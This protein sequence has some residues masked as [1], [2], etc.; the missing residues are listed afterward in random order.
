MSEPKK[1]KIFHADC[2]DI[3]PTLADN[4][5]HAVVSDPL[6]FKFTV[7]NMLYLLKT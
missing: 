7:F 4:S 5:I 6:T 2:M 3:L 1:V